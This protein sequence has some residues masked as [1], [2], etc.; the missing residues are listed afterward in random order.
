MLRPRGTVSQSESLGS[1]PTTTT[2]VS[3][4]LGGMFTSSPVSHVQ[5]LQNEDG[6]DPPQREISRY[7]SF[8]HWDFFLIPSLLLLGFCSSNFS[9][10][11]TF[12]VPC[13]ASL[14]LC[15]SL[16]AFCS[17]S[18]VNIFR[19]AYC[20]CLPRSSR[21]LFAFLCV[22]LFICASLCVSGFPSGAGGQEPACSAG[23][24]RDVGSIP[25]SEDPWRRAWQP[26]PVSLSGESHG[27]R[28]LVGCSPLGHK[29]SGTT[30][31]T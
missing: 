9:Y 8:C 6:L 22:T 13:H 23:D 28:S 14:P 10:L 3:G 2:S 20:L 29:E 25:E 19:I 27:Q 21:P 15:P 26:T 18:C 4:T 16:L 7:A 12:A 31:V 17:A 24:L 1:H 30:E 11:L 5:G